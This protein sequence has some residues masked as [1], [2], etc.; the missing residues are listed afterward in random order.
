M[1]TGQ[2]QSAHVHLDVET[3]YEKVRRVPASAMGTELGGVGTSLRTKGSLNQKKCPIPKG[4]Q[5]GA[6]E[7]VS[8]TQST[9]FRLL[10]HM[11]KRQ[12]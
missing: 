10:S 2:F 9:C 3:S 1:N 11:V 6:S 5:G 4:G 7:S 12:W 8:K